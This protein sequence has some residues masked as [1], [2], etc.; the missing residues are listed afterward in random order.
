MYLTLF[1]HAIIKLKFM[2]FVS[3]YILNNKESFNL[4]LLRHLKHC[5]FFVLGLVF[6]CHTL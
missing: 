2:Q 4:K 3:N 5:S 1:L 6:Y